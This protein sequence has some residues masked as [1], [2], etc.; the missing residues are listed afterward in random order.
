[1]SPDPDNRSTPE[2]ADPEWFRE[3]NRR[4]HLIAANL[5]I[6]CGLCFVMMFVVL[7]GWWPRWVILGLGVYSVIHGIRHGLDARKAKLAEPPN[8]MTIDGK[9]RWT[10]LIS[11]L[12]GILLVSGVLAWLLARFTRSWLVA[13]GLVSFMLGY[14]LLMGYVASHHHRR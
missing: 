1:M 4:E 10:G 14:M 12:L 11:Y 13:A 9:R 3:P 6:G 5:F 8:E 7:A 2:Q